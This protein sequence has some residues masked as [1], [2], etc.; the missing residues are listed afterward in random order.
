MWKAQK[1]WYAAKLFHL[2]SFGKCLP[3]D[4]LLPYWVALNIFCQPPRIIEF[5]QTKVLFVGMK[6]ANITDSA[7]KDNVNQDNTNRDNANE[8]NNNQNRDN[9]DNDNE[10]NNNEDN[11]KDTATYQRDL[12]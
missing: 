2:S 10:D 12:F 4:D 3:W 7:N 5:Q 11:H 6:W 8:N 9:R 1:K